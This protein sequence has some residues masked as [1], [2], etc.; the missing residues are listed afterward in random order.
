[1][2]DVV[3]GHPLYVV[4]SNGQQRLGAVQRLN[5]RFLLNLEH[6]WFLGWIEIQPIDLADLLDKERIGG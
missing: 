1:M 5:L 2:T 3:M 6:D 4:Q